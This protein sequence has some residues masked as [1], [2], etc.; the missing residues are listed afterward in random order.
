[1]SKKLEAKERNIVEP[2]KEKGE[3]RNDTTL[4]FVQTCRKY[5]EHISENGDCLLWLHRTNEPIELTNTIFHTLN[6]EDKISHFSF[7]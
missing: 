2:L 7:N 4:H 6:E 1:M 5:K 3:Y